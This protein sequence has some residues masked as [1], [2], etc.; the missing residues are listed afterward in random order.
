MGLAEVREAGPDD[1]AVLAGLQLEYWQQAY[2]TLLPRQLW[3]RGDGAQTQAWRERLSLPGPALLATESGT[4]V[5]FALVSG[6]VPDDG[7]DAGTGEV[8]AL[9]VLPRWS[10]RGHGGRLL[11]TAA[12]YLRRAGANRGRI[13]VPEADGIAADFLSAA[14]WYPDGTRR[15]LDTGAGTLAEVAHS[16]T[17]DLMLI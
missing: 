2:A 16:G 14:G 6:T 9:G 10:R 8:E 7:E 13:W 11:A 3:E 4:P 17:L 5:G 1:A 12:G 15:V